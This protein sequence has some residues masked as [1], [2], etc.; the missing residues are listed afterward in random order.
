MDDC[1]QAE[2]VLTQQVD[3]KRPQEKVPVQ[4]DWHDYLAND[5]H[6]GKR[7][8]LG[9]CIRPMR[10]Q[11]TGLEYEVTVAGVTGNRRP[12]FPV[13]AGDTIVSG[14]VTFRARAMTDSSLRAT[15][16]SSSFPSV[17]GITLSD[18]SDDDLVHTIYVSGG[19]AGGNYEVVNQIT[20]SNAPAELKA[21]VALL[22]VRG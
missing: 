17:D 22:P 16:A 5:W 8:E 13:N 15:I 1:C 14:T 4:F 2:R 11:A 9:A 6:R 20:L 3:A 21:G 18:Q 10:L 12:N 7:Y 19:T